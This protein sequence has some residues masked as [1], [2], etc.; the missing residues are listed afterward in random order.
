M[1]VAGV[2]GGL[3]DVVAVSVSGVEFPQA[4][5]VQAYLVYRVLQVKLVSVLDVAVPISE[6]LA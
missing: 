2:E 3:M 4:E 6:A 5:Y 1:P